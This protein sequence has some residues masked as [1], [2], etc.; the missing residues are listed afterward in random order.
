MIPSLSA[1]EL[2]QIPNAFDDPDWV[3]EIK[4]DGFRACSDRR[5]RMQQQRVQE[6]ACRADLGH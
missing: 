4:F 1:L 6:V 2:Q 5:Q 3:F